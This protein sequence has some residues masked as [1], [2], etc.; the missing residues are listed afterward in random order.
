M[1]PDSSPPSPASPVSPSQAQQ[2]TE[3]SGLTS[4]KWSPSPQGR[5]STSAPAESLQSSESTQTFFG[6]EFSQTLFPTTWKRKNSIGVSHKCQ[7]H[8]LG[9][10]RSGLSSMVLSMDVLDDFSGTEILKGADHFSSW[11]YQGNGRN[12]AKFFTV[13]TNRHVTRSGIAYVIFSRPEITVDAKLRS[14][15]VY[16][17]HT[18]NIVASPALR[19]GY[20]LWKVVQMLVQNLPRLSQVCFDGSGS[21]L[22]DVFYLFDVLP[23][24][25]TSIELKD[26]VAS[27]METEKIS[28]C[29]RKKY[30][31]LNSL[32]I[33][34]SSKTLDSL[35]ALILE[36]S[37]HCPEILQL[38]H[39]ML[40]DEQRKVCFEKVAR[41]NLINRIVLMRSS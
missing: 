27:S 38:N 25:L 8:S 20:K 34:P 11:T 30:S 35:L 22:G 37:I 23:I 12:L 1:Q 7:H 13:L 10:D 39:T 16:S 19:E 24:K 6:P 3:I 41:M 17:V 2:A 36:L 5:Q 9:T 32:T 18:L 21:A 40:N 26:L 31:K 29:I 4:A 14:P 15:Q 28:K 33:T